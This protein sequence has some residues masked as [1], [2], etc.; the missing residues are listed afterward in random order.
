MCRRSLSSRPAFA[1]DF[2]CS[3][4]MAF[5][6]ASLCAS[7]LATRVAPV[8][9]PAPWV[10]ACYHLAEVD[11][12]LEFRGVHLEVARVAEVLRGQDVDFE[13]GLFVARDVPELLE[14]GD[15]SLAACFLQLGFERADV[16]VVSGDESSLVLGQQ[17]VVPGL[18]LV[19]H[20]LEVSFFDHHVAVYLE[21]DLVEL[22]VQCHRRRGEAQQLCSRRGDDRAVLRGVGGQR[23]GFVQQLAFPEGL[24][25]DRRLFASE[26][27]EGDDGA[28]QDEVE[29]G[30]AD[31]VREE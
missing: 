11:R 20:Q 14:L 3:R 22:G 12:R 10:K 19:G 26:V 25:E 18:E 4:S 8:R 9:R 15:F 24:Q 13:G 6:S 28:F 27:S 21:D 2:I 30:L 1:E 7:S 5:R 29:T 31:V 23:R 17:V 16:D